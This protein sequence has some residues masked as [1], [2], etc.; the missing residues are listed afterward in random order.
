MVSDEAKR[1]KAMRQ[2]TRFIARQKHWESLSDA[3]Q[4]ENAQKF[5]EEY[6]ERLDNN[7][8]V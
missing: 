1:K 5:T 7:G 3:E 6:L 8:R 2:K 4:L